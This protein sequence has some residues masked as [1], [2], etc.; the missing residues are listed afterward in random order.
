MHPCRAGIVRTGRWTTMKRMADIRGKWLANSRSTPACQRGQLPAIPR[1]SPATSWPSDFRT[2]HHLERWLGQARQTPIPSKATGCSFEILMNRTA[3]R[4]VTSHLDRG[5]RTPLGCSYLQRM[6]QDGTWLSGPTWSCGGSR[7]PS[8]N[9]L[10]EV[11]SRTG[12][13]T[14]KRC[15]E[16]MGCERL[17]YRTR[18]IG[19][20]A[21]AYRRVMYTCLCHCS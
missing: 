2:L 5:A 19:R 6:S 12:L 17:S 3:C 9:C 4:I 10:T 11:S 16:V 20:L 8:R 7:A 18:I 13:W 15:G 14:D 1:T 21:R